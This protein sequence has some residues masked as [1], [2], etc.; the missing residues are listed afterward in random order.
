MYWSG[1]SLP[2]AGECIRAKAAP[3]VFDH[4]VENVSNVSMWHNC[5]VTYKVKLLAYD[6]KCSPGERLHKDTLGYAR[7]SAQVST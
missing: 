4:I 5:K 1:R 3:L 7:L 2:R 6:M